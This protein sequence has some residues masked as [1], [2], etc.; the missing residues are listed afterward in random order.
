M[1]FPSIPR[2]SFIDLQPKG[3]FLRAAGP[4]D[5]KFLHRL[6]RSLRSAELAMVDWSSEQ[7]AAFCDSQFALQHQHWIEHFPRGW[8]LILARRGVPIGRLYIDPPGDDYRII[9]IGLLPDWRGKGLGE[10]LLTGV[11]RL[12]QRD[13]VPVTLAV[14]HENQ[15][16]E[17]LYRRLGFLPGT[18]TARDIP[19]R[20]S[21]SGE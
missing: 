17:A 10:A 16:A 18:P 11:Q 2:A 19:M 14:L 13:G 7:K 6:Y 1:H 5:M 15:R 21:A 12:A 9:D 3:Y 8:F 20:W 4:D